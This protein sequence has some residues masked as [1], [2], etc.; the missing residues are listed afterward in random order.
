MNNLPGAHSLLKTDLPPPLETPSLAPHQGW[1]FM[2]NCF[3][4]KHSVLHIWTNLPVISATE[5]ME[6]SFTLLLHVIALWAILSRSSQAPS[7]LLFVHQV[8][9][10]L[11]SLPWLLSLSMIILESTHVFLDTIIDSVLCNIPLNGHTIGFL[12]TCVGPSFVTVW[13]H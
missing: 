10:V 6:M 9:P 12:L 8:T 4:L 11:L 3:L 7:A 13:G 5:M 2:I 1:G